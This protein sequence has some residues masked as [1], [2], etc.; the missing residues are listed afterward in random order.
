MHCYQTGAMESSRAAY[1]NFS[2]RRALANALSPDPL[3]KF[4]H[5]G[6]SIAYENE[7]KAEFLSMPRGSENLPSTI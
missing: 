4:R 6:E 3:R 2:F 1:Q 5:V 7:T